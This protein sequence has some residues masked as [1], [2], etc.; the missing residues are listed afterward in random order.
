MRKSIVLVI[1][2][3]F[4]A[5]LVLLTGCG[6][7][8]NTKVTVAKSQAAKPRSIFV[9]AGAGLRKPMDEIGTVFEKKT[10]IK[11]DYTYAGSPCLLAQID[12]AQ[13]GDAYMPGEWYYLEQAQKKGYLKKVETIAYVIPVIAVAK[14][15]PKHVRNLNDLTRKDL[16]V[17][18]G[19][20]HA[21]AL[22]KQAAVVLENAGLIKQ[23]KKNLT[24]EAAT[25]P[26]LI[27]GIKLGQLDAVIA[28]DACALWCPKDVDIVPIDA[29]YNAVSTVPLATLK[30][31]K[32]TAAADQFLQFVASDEGKAI[33]VKHGYSLTKESQFF[34]GGGVGAGK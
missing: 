25:V 24:T 14:G 11:V 4:L 30:F 16:R 32:D 3:I 33:F 7:Q 10:G 6:Q 23:V 8:K 29:R 26:D 15:N 17:G 22:G 12:T 19:D 28:W 9:L 18:I 13:E 20:P 34:K 2:A 21:T 5:S 1:L 31:A 27:N